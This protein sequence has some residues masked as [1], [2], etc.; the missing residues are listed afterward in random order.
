MLGD[1][2]SKNDDRDAVHIAIIP[3]EAGEDLNPGDHVCKVG[4]TVVKPTPDTLETPIGIVDP[5]LSP[6]LIKK[7]TTIWVC[8]YPNQVFGMR[9]HWKHQAFLSKDESEEWLRNYCSG[10]DCPSFEIL[11]GVLNEDMFEED[12]FNSDIDD[13]VWFFTGIDAHSDIPNEFWMHAENYLDK[14]FYYKPT[15]FSCSC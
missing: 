8:L 12:D 9:H 15:R 7:G 4:N 13:D 2:P 14:K 5:F 1:L 11:M 6:R 10:H 3:M